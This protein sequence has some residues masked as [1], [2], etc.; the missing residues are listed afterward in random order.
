MNCQDFQRLFQHESEMSLPMRR[1]HGACPACDQYSEQIGRLRELLRDYPRV[2]PSP[3]FDAEVTA[4]LEARSWL[5]RWDNV[6]RFDRKYAWAATVLVS[7]AAGIL[8]LRSTG[9]F[10]SGMPKREIAKTVD[11]ASRSTEESLASGAPSAARDAEVARAD[12]GIM[13]SRQD[14]SLA[15]DRALRRVSSAS[16]G[17]ESGDVGLTLFLQD[18]ASKE[19]RVISVPSVVLGAQPLL[20]SSAR[21]MGAD[22]E[23]IF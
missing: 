19:V 23:V 13:A 2:A 17:T 7:L 20:P 8:V 11:Q 21:V 6:G 15:F 3:N 9:V 18:E 10:Q 4:R 16:L 22:S 1:H 12:A 5:R 14:A